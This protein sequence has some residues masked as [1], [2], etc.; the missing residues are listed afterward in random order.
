L[1]DISKDL[2]DKVRNPL[3]RAS[4]KVSSPELFKPLSTE[5]ENILR[6]IQ[7]LVSPEWKLLDPNLKTLVEAQ[8]AN[9]QD[10]P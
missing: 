8:R 4:S 3:D 2:D 5:M 7:D 9:L 1:N 10:G 6:Q